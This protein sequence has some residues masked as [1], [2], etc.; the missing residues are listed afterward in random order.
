[1]RVIVRQSLANLRGHRLQAGLIATTL[2]AASALLAIAGLARTSAVDSWDALRRQTGDTHV[3]LRLDPDLVEPDEAYRTITN[4]PGAAEVA[5]PVRSVEI[6]ALGVEGFFSSLVVREWTAGVTGAPLLVDGR[7][8]TARERA[9]VVLDRNLAAISGFRVG[10]TLTIPTG[11]EPLRFRVVGLA[12][13]SEN[14]PFP[15]CS[16]ARVFVAPGTFAAL[17]LDGPADPDAVSDLVAVRLDDPGALEAFVARASGALPAGA[18]R[19]V[20]DVGEIR[21]VIGV[22]LN[23]QTV[24]FAAFGLVASLVAG[25]LIA[26]AVAGA[27]RSETRAIGILKSVG[28]TRRQVAG[29]YLG[30]YLGLATVAGLVGATAGAATAGPLLRPLTRQFGMPPPGISPLQILFVA[31]LVVA[32]TGACAGWPLRRVTR[33]DT[34]AAIRTGAERPRGRGRSVGRLPTVAATA[35]ADLLAR[36]ARAA[37]TSSAL[38]VAVIALVW[39]VMTN[40]MMGRVITD[41]DISLYGDADA[42]VQRSG[43]LADANLRAMLGRRPEVTAVAGEQ[44]RDFQFAGGAETYLGRFLDGDID[45]FRAPLV[46]G[47][48]PAA[49]DEAVLGYGMARQQGLGVGDRVHVQVKGL[50]LTFRVTGVIREMNNLGEMITMPAE[51]LGNDLRRAGPDTY[52]VKLRTGATV[53]E[54]R[55]AVRDATGGLADVAPV[56]SDALPRTIRDLRGVLL[57]LTAILSLLVGVGV[58]SAMSLSVAERRREFGV[59]KAVGMT[60]KQVMGS[61]LTGASVLAATAFAVGLPAGIFLGQMVQRNVGISI[62]LGPLEAPMPFGALALI[63]PVVALLAL[64]GAGLPGRSASR[65]RPSEVL[66]FE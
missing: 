34:V 18:V 38:V 62:G 60:P 30:E 58:L 48:M 8:P 55:A 16:P 24:L 44:F 40:Q 66:A 23:V 64:V 52:M 50:D 45:A 57:A 42:I 27:V 47:R 32:V 28:F 61:V 21:D 3:W 10:D 5:P 63:L 65:T 17:G 39:V 20:Q 25:I 2:L 31:G 56:D 51:A 29:V 53:A 1:V 19:Q 9:T 22:A 36:P 7:A 6:R 11:G 46:E 37:L 33:V 59:L 26:N 4:L 54:L 13:S 15:V 12:V 43:L 41:P 49:R 14:C 35:V